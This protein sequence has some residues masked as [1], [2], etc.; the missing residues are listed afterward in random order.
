[1][2]KRKY[3]VSSGSGSISIDFVRENYVR[4]E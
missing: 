3:F 4:K 1:M 2:V